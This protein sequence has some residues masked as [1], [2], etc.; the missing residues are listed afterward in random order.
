MKSYAKYLQQTGQA[1]GQLNENMLYLL[2]Y[3]LGI[4][5]SLAVCKPIVQ[6]PYD[7]VDKVVY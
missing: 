3:G 6:H 1:G 5:K 4:T 7:I 2:M